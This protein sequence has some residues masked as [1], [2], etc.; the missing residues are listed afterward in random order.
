MKRFIV[1]FPD[2]EFALAVFQKLEKIEDGFQFNPIEKIIFRDKEIKIRI[3]DNVRKSE[4]FFVHDS[5]HNPSDWFLELAFVNEAL[6]NS[7]AS[8][9]TDVLPY[10][11]FSRQDRKDKSRV[12]QNIKVVADVLNTCADR[13]VTLD[14]HAPQIAL[15]CSIPFDNLYSFPTVIDHL[16]KNHPSVL[17]NIMLMSPDAGGVKRVES[18]RNRLSYCG[19][20]SDIA[21]G[22]K[23]RPRE[24]EIGVFKMVGDVENK[25]VIIIDDIIDS[26]KTLVEAA[27]ELRKKGAKKIYA[28]GTHALFTE[29]VYKAVENFERIFVSDTLKQTKHE[30]LEIISVT[31]LFAEAIKRISKGESLSELFETKKD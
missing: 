21:I 9:I 13:A 24:G 17:E 22:Y 29:G 8:E 20:E 11:R 19:I 23:S 16:I 4:C 27:Q 18:F 3:R 31:G 30:K 14:V 25:N 28:Y 10:L 6:H 2:D 1:A 5:N 12:A 7:S 15:A 26:G